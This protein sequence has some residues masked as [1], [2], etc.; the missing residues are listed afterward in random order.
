MN[1]LVF[2]IKWYN[3]PNIVDTI[4]TILNEIFAVIFMTEALFKLIGFG[5][6][7]FRDGWNNF[8]L[9]NVVLS[10]VGIIL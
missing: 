1:T 7:Y 5:K 4:T 10:I 6:G 8:D 3:Q 9:I 2:M